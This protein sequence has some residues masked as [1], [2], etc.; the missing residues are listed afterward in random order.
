MNMTELHLQPP[1]DSPSPWSDG[2]LT[3]EWDDFN[4]ASDELE[5]YHNPKEPR[6]CATFHY[7]GEDWDF[8]NDGV[9]IFTD[10]MGEETQFS[11]DYLHPFLAPYRDRLDKAVQEYIDENS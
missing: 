1:E 4:L 2:T 3:W 10:S 9:V 5:G 6:L 11:V 7:D 8:A